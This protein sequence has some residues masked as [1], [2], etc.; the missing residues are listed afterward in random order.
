VTGPAG[1]A[2][3][4]TLEPPGDTAGIAAFARAWAK[5]I[6]G[7]C[8]LPM[9]QAE[10]E[11]FLRGLT[12]RMARAIGAEPLD[13]LT[14]HRIGAD[15]VA[16]HLTSAETLG[17]TIEVIELRLLRDL[18]L[19]GAD[20]WDRIARL[21]GSVATGYARA[22]RD[23]TLDE[24]ESIRRA[25]LVARAQAERALR[26][27][28]A[29]F[30]HQATHDPL[31]GLPNRALFTERLHAVFGR[32]GPPDRRLG[33]CFVDLDGFKVVNDTLGHSVGD[34]LLV[35]VADRLRRAIPEPLVARLGGDEFV[36]LLDDTAG[37]DDAVKVAD[38]TLAALADPFRVDGHEVTVSASIGIVEQPVDGGSP[39]EVMRAAD[40]TLHWAKAAGKNRWAQFDAERNARELARHALSAAM[41]AAVSRGEFFLDYQP[42]VS[43]TT[44]AVLG[45]EALVR[46]RHPR[47]GV[48]RPDRFIG[49]AEETGLIVRLG[50]WVF[51]EACDQARRWY[52]RQPAAP[53]VSINL[54]VRQ[55]HDP[56]LVVMITDLL[57][58][59]GLPPEKVQLE[60]TESALIGNA[61]EPVH[62]LRTLADIGMRIAIDDF[63]TGYSNLAYL[64]HLPVCELKVAAS[65]VA[66]LGQPAHDPTSGT[67][68]RILVTLV[69]LAHAL[70]LTVTAEGVETQAQVERLRAIGCDTAQGWYF[71]RPGPPHDIYASLVAP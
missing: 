19:S 69:S 66:G 26:A 64:R 56:S 7:T 44:G 24:Q 25:A 53:F 23:R 39:S 61:N 28:E 3:A 20:P 13:P 57:R 32:G 34:L 5:A 35:L 10:L 68:E 71:G 54:A 63:G 41:P 40:A 14:G 49:L 60:I 33:V 38:A 59:I 29:R 55:V 12:A 51:A 37:T 22:L 43:L 52:E 47:L 4:G 15:M 42:L 36:I 31:T 70:G 50:W 58:R 16:A 46:W 11:G 8:Y 6:T 1:P 65:F 27:S 17:R 67:D 18:G 21:L 45:V 62:A 48:L 2:R 30:R 9:T